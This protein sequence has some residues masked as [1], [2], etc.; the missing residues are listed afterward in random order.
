MKK[1]CSRKVIISNF[2]SLDKKEFLVFIPIIIK[3]ELRT[4]NVNI[5]I[6]SENTYCMKLRVK[7]S[8]VLTIFMKN[9]QYKAGKKAS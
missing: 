7:E 5:A 2:D 4:K 8:L 1:T 3:S 6:I 9:I